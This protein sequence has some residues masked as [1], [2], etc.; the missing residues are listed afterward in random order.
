MSQGMV[1]KSLFQNEHGFCPVLPRHVEAVS[2]VVLP[3][4]EG[5][6]IIRDEQDLQK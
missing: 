4:E 5:I 3:P 6:E 2:E 1:G